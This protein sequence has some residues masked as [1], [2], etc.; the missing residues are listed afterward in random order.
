M[1]VL[2]KPD[3]AIER[4]TQQAVLDLVQGRRDDLKLG[5]YVLKNRDADDISSTLAERNMKEKAFFAKDPWSAIA[6]TGRT[7]IKAVKDRL[8]DLL[9]H[10]TKKEFPHVK[11]EISKRLRQCREQQQGL[12]SPRSDA[13]AQRAYLGRLATNF[14]RVATCALDANYVHDKIFT[15]KPEMK[16]ITRII[17]LNEEFAHAFWQRGHFRKFDSV[18]GS[19][20]EDKPK[21]LRGLGFDIP[22]DAYPE[23][24]GII[25][26]DCYECAEPLEDSILERIETV[27][28][29]SR[30]AELGTVSTF[31]NNRKLS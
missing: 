11:T 2:T 30:G 31:L 15:T 17:E 7:G 18:S 13:H 22:Y 12:G 14:Q 25:V 5:Y 27:F 21:A 28:N 29:S 26:R 1:G 20:E 19:D 23:L 24:D 9:A 3:L 10:I 6:R 4:A 16:L 8:S